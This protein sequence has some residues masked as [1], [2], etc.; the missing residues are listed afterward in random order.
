MHRREKQVRDHWRPDEDELRDDSSLIVPRPRKWKFR[1]RPPAAWILPV[2]IP[3]LSLILFALLLTGCEIGVA[4]GLP[5][6]D[7]CR[8]V[9]TS[10]GDP[11]SKEC[12]DTIGKPAATP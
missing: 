5:R 11:I 10:P 2:A 6:N 3:I 1:A 4:L 8:D 12:L 9:D 7:E